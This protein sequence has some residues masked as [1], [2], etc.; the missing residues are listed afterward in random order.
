M[1]RTTPIW[2]TLVVSLTAGPMP[3]AAQQMDAGQTV[4]VPAGETRQ[5]DFYAAGESIEIAGSLEGD[6]VAAGQR[7]QTTGPIDGDLFAAA[8]TIDIRGSVGDSTRLAGELITVDAAIDGDVVVAGNRCHL[9]ESARVTGGVR[10]ACATVDVD[11]TVDRNLRAVGGAVTVRGRV[12]GNARLRADRVALGPGARIDGNLDYRAR[13]PLSPEEAARV[14][15]TVVYN[16]LIDDDRA[17]DITTGR[18][19]FWGWQAAAALLAGILA[20]ALFR[21]LLPQLAATISGNTTVGALLG[22]AAF[23]VVPAGSIVVMVTVIGL[24]VGLAAVLLFLVALYVAKLPVALWTGTRLLTLAGR[25]GASRY[26]AMAV[27]IVML[28]ALFSI[29]YLGRLIWLVSTWLGLGAMVL[30][31][32]AYLRTRSEA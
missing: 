27:G 31:G 2:L 26:L 32:R 21:G 9:L 6:L 28:Y 15:G 14:G 5:G 3:A 13:T 4:R 12:R 7:I 19:L 8:R 23:L 11:G 29:P 25:P 18:L 1:A 10:A 16:E 30:T 22:F 24:P 17:S 20:I